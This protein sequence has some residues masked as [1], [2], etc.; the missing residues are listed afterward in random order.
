MADDAGLGTGT[1]ADDFR[2]EDRSRGS[3][4]LLSVYWAFVTVTTVGYGDVVPVNDIERM[5]AHFEFVV[6]LCLVGSGAHITV[7]LVA[8]VALSFCGRGL[9]VLRVCAAL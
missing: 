4:Y 2:M 6:A 9:L 5:Y 8:C 7:T 3:R 1:W